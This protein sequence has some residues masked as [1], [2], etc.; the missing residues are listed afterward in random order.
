MKPFLVG[1]GAGCAAT[2]VIQPVDQIKVR[3]RIIS[4]TSTGE[5]REF[6]LQMGQRRRVYLFFACI[7]TAP[8]L[9]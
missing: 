6:L 9:Y 4:L 7:S 1:G 5:P 3:P 2:V 8:L